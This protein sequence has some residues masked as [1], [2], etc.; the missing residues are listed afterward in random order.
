VWDFVI[1]NPPD[2]GLPPAGRKRGEAF[3]RDHSGPQK[4]IVE[5]SGDDPGGIEQVGNL[6]GHCEKCRVKEPG[7]MIAELK[8]TVRRLFGNVPN[9]AHHGG[10]HADQGPA[11]NIGRVVQSEVDSG[12]GDENEHIQ[13][14]EQEDSPGNEV[15]PDRY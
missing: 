11:E 4:Q 1:K 3:G 13:K 15:E 12:N 14:G 2:C 9:I 6:I 7:I 5:M 8:H 10:C